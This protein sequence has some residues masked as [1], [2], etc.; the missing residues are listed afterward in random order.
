MERYAEQLDDEEMAKN[1]V[2]IPRTVHEIGTPQATTYGSFA[3]SYPF[4]EPR[5]AFGVGRGQD[6]SQN[7]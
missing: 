3:P 5:Q 7:V 1:T 4:T 2:V 6:P